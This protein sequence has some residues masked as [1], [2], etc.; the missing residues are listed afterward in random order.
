MEPHKFNEDVS[1]TLQVYRRWSDASAL[2]AWRHCPEYLTNWT[3]F[4][5]MLEEIRWTRKGRLWD[6]R[7]QDRNLEYT[8]TL[9][10]G[11]INLWNTTRDLLR[12]GGRRQDIAI[13]MKAVIVAAIPKITAI[14]LSD[15][16]VSWLAFRMLV[17]SNRENDGDRKIVLTHYCKKSV[18]I[19]TQESSRLIELVVKHCARLATVSD[20]REKTIMKQVG[21]VELVR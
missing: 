6:A 12:R 21:G 15:E 5:G 4:G 14:V 19:R 7:V 1:R 10:G 20:R 18:F 13:E 8:K 11:C 17:H 16:T 9:A 3:W 2:W